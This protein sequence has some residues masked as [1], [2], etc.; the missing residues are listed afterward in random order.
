MNASAEL[1]EVVADEHFVRLIE[2][3]IYSLVLNYRTVGDWYLEILN[4]IIPGVSPN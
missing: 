3:D 2:E 4:S 1:Q